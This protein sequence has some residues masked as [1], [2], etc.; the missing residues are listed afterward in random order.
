MGTSGRRRG[1]PRRVVV[2]QPY[3]AAYREAL[4]QAVADRLSPTELVVLSGTPSRELRARG[5]AAVEHPWLRRVPGRTVQIRGTSA[6]VQYK[7]GVG[8]WVRSADVV[9]AE[10]SVISLNS[11]WLAL[12]RASRLVLWGHGASF[13]AAGGGLRDRLEVLQARRAHRVLTYSDRG[14]ASLLSRGLPADRVR[15]IGNSTDTRR[16]RELLPQAGPR[17]AELRDRFGL[18][19]GRTAVFVGGLDADKRVDFLLAAAEH[20]HR[21]DPDFRLLVAGD[22]ED[23]GRVR[24]A[25]ARTPA[26]AH[27]GRADAAELAALGTVAA[28]MWMPG[29]VGLVAVDCL[30][31]GVPV[32]TTAFPF[33]APEVEF[34]REGWDRFTLPDDPGDFAAAAL[35]RMGATPAGPT[36]T[37]VPSIEDVADRFAVAVADLLPTGR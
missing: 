34:L 29:R 16:L 11:W 28:A 7:R 19:P 14:R 23:A 37:P 5:D 24:A 12:T 33:H 36:G 22:G 25:A 21:L 9:V 20:A 2:L 27:L 1:G 30:A 17:A 18:T 26:V 35:E 8:R 32:L 4:W 10:L 13:V 3:V 31:L 15:A 6:R